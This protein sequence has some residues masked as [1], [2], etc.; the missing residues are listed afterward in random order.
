MSVESLLWNVLGMSYLSP[1]VLLIF[2]RVRGKC[3]K[4]DMQIVTGICIRYVNSDYTL[5]QVLLHLVDQLFI[6]WSYV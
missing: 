6:N 1:L 3:A 2:R 5:A 4:S